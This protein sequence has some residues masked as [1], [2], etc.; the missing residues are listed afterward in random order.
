MNT[1]LNQITQA[2]Q[3]GVLNL[4]CPPELL[5]NL[6]TQTRDLTN[7]LARNVPGTAGKEILTTLHK[8]HKA[9]INLTSCDQK[10]NN[11]MSQGDK[12]V[13]PQPRQTSSLNKE[14]A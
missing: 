1:L 14:S 10:Q 6:C 9:L 11:T 3:G 5:Q 4:P 2:S 8:S 13:R 12:A 7:H